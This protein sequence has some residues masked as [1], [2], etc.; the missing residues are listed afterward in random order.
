[1][2]TH[3][4]FI[5]VLALA[6]LFA[7][8]G[9]SD[10]TEDSG[11]DFDDIENEADVLDEDGKSEPENE[12]SV[13]LCDAQSY[14]IGAYFGFS[15][16]FAASQRKSLPFPAWTTL[17]F[18]YDASR[19]VL[20]VT[21]IWIN[22]LPICACGM[23]WPDGP[24]DIPGSSEEKAFLDDHGVGQGSGI[25]TIEVNVSDGSSRAV[26]RDLGA[27][28]AESLEIENVVGGGIDP[29]EIEIQRA[30]GSTQI[31]LESS[32]GY[33][34]RGCPSNT[35]DDT[36]VLDSLF[37]ESPFGG[38]I[39]LCGEDHNDQKDCSLPEPIRTLTVLPKKQPGAYLCDT[40]G[41]RDKEE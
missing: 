6:W 29:F 27:S 8:C 35:P 19:D 2:K 31:I 7:G 41:C 40:E 30:G 25:L 22:K 39:S 10:P 11:G 33:D 36:R 38:T 37:R 14:D 1:M 24:S 18:E 23:E 9:D 16:A 13:I 4:L 20:H 34:L 21:G 32:T 3:V 17:D 12:E 26:Q 28:D 15:E 5:G